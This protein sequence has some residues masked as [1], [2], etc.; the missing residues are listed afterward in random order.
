LRRPL[1]LTLASGVFRIRW[2]AGGLGGDVGQD[3]RGEIAKMGKYNT[4]MLWVRMC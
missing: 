3:M 1:Q 2:M 4:D